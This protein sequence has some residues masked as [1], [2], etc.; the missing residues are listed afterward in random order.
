MTRVEVNAG[1]CGHSA[2]IDVTRLDDRH[3]RVV[4]SSE[5]EQLTAMN[6]A[7]AE[8]QWKGK[9]HQ[10]FGRMIESAVFRSASQEIRHT[11]CPIPTAILKA[12]EA[13]VGL[14]VPHDV[15]IRFHSVDSED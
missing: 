11:A 6:P 15:T 12:I 7:L 8:L 13:E 1:D 14:A 3:V 5:C 4:L 9:G 10:V 2:V